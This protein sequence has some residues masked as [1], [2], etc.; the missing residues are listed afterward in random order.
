MKVYLETLVCQCH[1]LFNC[2]LIQII[3]TGLNLKESPFT[4]GI[5][6]TKNYFANPSKTIHFLAI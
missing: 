4:T 2:P 1:F 5:A 6:A 3:P